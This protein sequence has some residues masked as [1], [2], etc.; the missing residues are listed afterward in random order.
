MNRKLTIILIIM[1]IIPI[2]LL[3][4]MGFT[5]IQSEKDRAKQQIQYIGKQKLELVQEN[6]TLLFKEM[7]S[8]INKF[9]DL[10]GTDIDNIRISQREQKLIQQVFLLEKDGLIYPSSEILISKREDD[11]LT[12]I[13]ETDISVNFLLKPEAETLD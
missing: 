10:V 5:S 8:Y 9:L 6:I 2:G 4:W 13:K 1:V 7:E 3:S 12:R 11:F